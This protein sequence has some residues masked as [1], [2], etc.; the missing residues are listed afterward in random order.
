MRQRM[1]ATANDF[2]AS[3]SAGR[4]LGGVSARPLVARLIAPPAEIV[5]GDV[6]QLE[7]EVFWPS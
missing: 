7:I 4:A 5:R 2:E 6:W 1:G 3:E